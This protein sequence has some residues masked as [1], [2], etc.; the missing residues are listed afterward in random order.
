[1]LKIKVSNLIKKLSIKDISKD[2]YRLKIVGPFGV[3]QNYFRKEINVSLENDTICLNTDV[4]VKET[5]S[6]L[7]SYKTILKNSFNDVDFGFSVILEVR[8]VGTKVSYEPKEGSLVFSLGLSH[9]VKYNLPEGVIAKILDDKNTIFLLIGSNRNLVLST[10]AK[11]R[12]L[13]KKDMYKGKGIF[14]FAEEIS[15]KEGKGKN[16]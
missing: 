5:K 7:Q 15:L 11:I 9:S 13:K 3:I 16:A 8:G 2:Y 4:F 6:L 1:M 14:F 10:A 12:L